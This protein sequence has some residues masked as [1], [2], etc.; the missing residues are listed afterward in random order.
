MIIVAIN[1]DSLAA[2]NA[3]TGAPAVT[4]ELV[5]HLILFFF[6]LSKYKQAQV[7]RMRF[8]LIKNLILYF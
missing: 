6:F 7:L 8:I 5:L 1:R 4:A 2:F 3:I